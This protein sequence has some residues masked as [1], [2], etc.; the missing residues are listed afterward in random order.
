MNLKL[1]KAFLAFQN[2]TFIFQL[3]LAKER[4]ALEY[5]L[6]LKS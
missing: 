6:I 4:F 3:K 1:Y 5:N 2:V